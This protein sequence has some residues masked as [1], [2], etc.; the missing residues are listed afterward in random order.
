MTEQV[1]S[2]LVL[3][4]WADR[5]VSAMKSRKQEVII[6]K[7]LRFNLGKR[8]TKKLRIEVIVIIILVSC[9]N[10][11][12]RASATRE[13][14]EI[15]KETVYSANDLEVDARTFLNSLPPKLQAQ[16]HLVP[17]DEVEP[18]HYES[19]AL[20]I[21]Q[22]PRDIRLVALGQDGKM[23]SMPAKSQEGDDYVSAKNLRMLVQLLS[24][25]SKP[26]SLILIESEDLMQH[27]DL[28][29]MY[30]FSKLSKVKS[31][32]GQEL[33]YAGQMAWIRGGKIFAQDCLG[34]ITD[35][36]CVNKLLQAR[37]LEMDAV[38]T[39]PEKKPLAQTKLLEKT[40]QNSR[41]KLAGLNLPSANLMNN[42]VTVN[43]QIDK[44]LDDV[45][46][47]DPSL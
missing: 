19:A 5:K 42:E 12:C 2:L 29:G 6:N 25:I 4:A 10:A 21:Y 20:F 47:G 18:A 13:V 17:L 3:L 11:G 22:R 35:N 31:I 23:I 43:K 1:T 39:E 27:R 45:V 24:K 28:G 7:L 38:V 44:I 15:Q 33:H 41:R 9:T 16:C 40:I 37:I 30:D 34:D 46:Y 32:W 36:E 8:P 14:T 26:F